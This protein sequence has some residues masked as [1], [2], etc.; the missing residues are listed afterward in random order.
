[1]KKLTKSKFARQALVLYLGIVAALIVVLLTFTGCT[2]TCQTTTTYISYEPVL[3]SMSS[4]REE[5]DVLPPQPRE[6]QGKIYVYGDYLFLGDPGKGI[7]IF[8]N[9]DQ[10][11]PVSISFLNI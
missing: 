4:I 1:M 9:S 2:D 11:N 6:L 3:K 10:S 8:N 5:V 7:H